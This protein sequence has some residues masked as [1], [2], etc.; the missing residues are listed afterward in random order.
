MYE[1]RFYE[2]YLIEEPTNEV[3]ELDE[4]SQIVECIV[5]DSNEVLPE[6]IEIVEHVPTVNRKSCHICG[7]EV[8]AKAYYQHL[9]RAHKIGNTFECDFCGKVCSLKYDL[10]MHIRKHMSKELRDKYPCSICDSV[11]L[12]KSALNSHFKSFHSEI[13][14]IHPCDYNDCYKSFQTR[15]K[16]LQHIKVAHDTSPHPC[17]FCNKFFT[18]RQYLQKHIK[19]CHSVKE[20]EICGTCG[21]SVRQ[22]NQYKQHVLSHSENC[23]ECPFENCTNKFQFKGS[24]SKHIQTHHQPLK[25]VQCQYCNFSFPTKRHLSRHISRQHNDFKVECEVHGCKQLFGRKDY[26]TAHYK[27]H[28]DIDIETKQALLDRVKSIKVISW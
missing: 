12:S 1:C 18:T 24:L 20:Y 6:I 19:Q 9:K 3:I 28:K 26:L 21:K 23:F 22:G 7:Q 8:T 14:E 11:L 2:E 5:K 10:I 15:T 25:A 17:E 4:D 13:F 27:N 16:L